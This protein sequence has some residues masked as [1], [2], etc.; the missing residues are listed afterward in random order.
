M[1]LTWS[2][3]ESTWTTLGSTWATVG[4]V[5]GTEPA[6]PTGVTA[7][8]SS[9]TSITVSWGAA[10]NAIAYD[11][12]SERWNGSAWT[13]QT[14]VVEDHLTTSVLASGLTPNTL[15]RFRVRSVGA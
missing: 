6:V 9:T 10:A 4:E 1:S 5:G 7:V 11:V 3:L 12:Q 14:A 2:D 8:A 15:Y 13:D